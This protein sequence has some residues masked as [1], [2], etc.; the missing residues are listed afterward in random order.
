MSF[1]LF[2]KWLKCKNLPRLLKEA[3]KKQQKCFLTIHHDTKETHQVME[4]AKKDGD[5]HRWEILFKAAL[6]RQEL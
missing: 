5:H 6:S 1:M 4:G 2:Q 3:K